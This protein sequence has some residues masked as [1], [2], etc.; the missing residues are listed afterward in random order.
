MRDLDIEIRPT[1]HG[2]KNTA[3]VNRARKKP[4]SGNCRTSPYLMMMKEAARVIVP[5]TVTYQLKIERLSLDE[6]TEKEPTW[7]E[8]VHSF[9]RV[10]RREYL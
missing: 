9:V 8:L 7:M 2:I 3:A 1:P 6:D 10:S 4:H 5:P